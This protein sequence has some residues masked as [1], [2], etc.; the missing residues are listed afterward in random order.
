ML[1]ID[2]SPP[3]L[4]P[5]SPLDP[6]TAPDSPRLPGSRLFE[7]MITSFVAGLAS[8]LPAVILAVLQ[9]LSWVVAISL[10]IT[11]AAVAIGAYGFI[12][13]RRAARLARRSTAESRQNLPQRPSELTLHGGQEDRSVARY[14]LSDAVFTVLWNR[15]VPDQP[16][17]PLAL[18]DLIAERYPELADH[19]GPEDLVRAIE[20]VRLLRRLPTLERNRNGYFVNSDD[21]YLKRT[22][23]LEAKRQVAFAAASYVHPGMS[24]AFDGGTTTLQVA[25][26][27]I[28][29]IISKTLDRIRLTTCSIQICSEFLAI[30]EC[31]EAIRDG[32]LEVWSMAGP[33]HP[34][35]WTMDPP[36]TE[37]APWP[38]DLAI[39]GANG[40]TKEGFYLP[41]RDGLAVKQTL[42]SIAPVTLI[43]ADSSKIGRRL[44]EKFC[45]W[46]DGVRLITD[47][48][49]DAGTRRLLQSFPKA[50]VILSSDNKERRT[51]YS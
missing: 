19:N 47:R 24:I 34:S 9:K 29:R 49:T 50:E 21:F 27:L 16:M 43:A 8:A 1:S 39:I 40:I 22:L 33:L 41:N 23:A 12:S 31:R 20:E 28:T 51:L 6:E 15:A 7:N 35:C 5:T 4:Q 2:G 45:S 48:P 46:S 13:G 18:V 42:I 3:P 17:N 10:S 37:L 30:P 44:P 36:S 26:I 32:D 25:R 38:L 11:C 14:E